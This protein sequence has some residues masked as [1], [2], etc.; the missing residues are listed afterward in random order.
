MEVNP[1]EG[2]GSC[3]V[4]FKILVQVSQLYFLISCMNLGLNTLFAISARYSNETHMVENTT[5][6][7]YVA[8]HH[9]PAWQTFLTHVQNNI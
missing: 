1:K 4:D 7:K 2:M 5:A 9:D 8:M 3:S 6:T